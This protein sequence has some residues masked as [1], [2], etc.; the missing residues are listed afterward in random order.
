MGISFY[1]RV[2]KDLL[3]KAIMIP[4]PHAIAS[5]ISAYARALNRLEN[6]LREKNDSICSLIIEPIVQGAAGMLMWPKGVLKKVAELCKKYDVF[7]IADEVA[8]GFGRTGK[9]FACDHEGVT[10]DI[11]CLAK[12][13]SGGY[14]PIA[15][16]LATQKI[17]DGFSFDYKEN[18]T[19]LHGHTYT[20]NPL[21][22]AAALA[23]I[24]VFQ[25]EKTLEKLQ[26]KI[27]YL[28]Q[29]LKRFHA[30]DCVGE[31]R[32]R[33]FMVG[34]ELVKN[35]NTMEPF[36]WTKE[37]GIKVCQNVRKMGV[38][39]RPLRDVIV[40]MPPLSISKSELRM[41]LDAVYCAIK[42]ETSLC[43]G[44]KRCLEKN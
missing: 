1:Q 9:M 38:I 5:P 6:L 24:E 25:K 3:F 35:K 39:L 44:D 7:L 15:A 37:M 18:K 42:E 17:F 26:P 33:G 29:G 30:L 11:M 40:L 10:P 32:Q 16:T 28:K 2:Y 23:N 20:G 41:L 4:F 36:D 22:C 31:V 19:F 43:D 21:S 8:T 34:I 27:Q 12:G 14:L 13:L